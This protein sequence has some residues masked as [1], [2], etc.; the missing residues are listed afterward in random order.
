MR[1]ER[2]DINN[3]FTKFNDAQTIDLT[4]NKSNCIF[5][6]GSNGTGKSSL[7]K[8]FYASNLKLDMNDRYKENLSLLKTINSENNMSVS[9]CY[10]DESFTTFDN[11]DIIN[12][13]KIP[14]FNKYYIDSKI[15]YQSNFKNN[16]FQEQFLNYGI[17]LE[18]KTKYNQKIQELEENKSKA[19]ELSESANKKIENGIL[20]TIKDTGTTKA[21]QKYTNEYNFKHFFN[22]EPQNIPTDGLEK[23][24]DGHK[25]FISSLKDLNE[26]DSIKFNINEFNNLEE[27]KK[28]V[29]NINEIIKFN[30]DK[31]KLDFVK[32]YLDNFEIDKKDWK[33]Q[34]TY[35][36]NDNKCPFCEQDTSNVNIVNMY[37]TYIESNLKKTEDFINNQIKY[38]E[39]E[40]KNIDFQYSINETKA[41]NIDK[42]FQ[43]NVNSEL[44]AFVDKIKDFNSQIID[45]LKKKSE[46]ENIYID[47]TSSLENINIALLDES[48]QNYTSLVK[49]ISE[50]NTKIDNGKKEKNKSN[51]EYLNTTGKYLVYNLVRDDLNE[52]KKL[53]LQSKKLNDEIIIL[54]K[55]Y[56]EEVKDKNEL[57]K[58]INNFL[59]DFSITNYRVNENFD[60]FLNDCEVSSS[61]E[62]LLSDGEKNIIA[63]ALFLSELKLLYTNDEK[64]VIFIDDPITSVDYPNLYSMYNHIK[65]IISENRNSQ[66]IVTS[67]NT[68]FLNLFKFSY[69]NNALYFKLKEDEN[70]KTR[71]YEDTDILDSIYLEKLKEI[72]NISV[73][74]NINSKQKLYIHNYCRYVLET[75]SRFEYPNYNSDS[76]SSINY[77]NEL[78]NQYKDIENSPISKNNLDVL[79]NI[80]NK[81]SHATLEIVHDNELFDDKQYIKCCNTIIAIIRDKYNGQYNLLTKDI[82][83][84]AKTKIENNV[85]VTELN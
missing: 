47:C 31:S 77:I 29:I 70:E 39:N 28:N 54:K 74:K 36:I 52:F 58:T 51:E 56:Q 14:V 40:N 2:I 27:L 26:D 65:N 30:E 1:I 55:E 66:I 20:Q 6:Y 83:L 3:S 62:K 75:I 33:I 42:I 69:K 24:R 19:I 11:S 46:D 13:K 60:L 84:E 48:L 43:S 59:N 53:Y 44:K 25:G 12:P 38:F 73:S 35:F 72:Y 80:V 82:D 9:I 68:I 7:S 4:E 5:I 57:L 49:Y 71:I 41:K 32:Q 81:G 50:L 34:G 63:F 18:S 61:A 78:K 85:V 22:L 15:T 17:E 10:N 37:K 79:S 8:L 67:H 76:S 45:L 23:F 16:K 21:N 64:D